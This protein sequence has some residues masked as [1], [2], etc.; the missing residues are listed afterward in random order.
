L[1]AKY[2][3]SVARKA[4]IESEME[5]TKVKLTRAEKLLSGL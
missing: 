4:K 1:R 5:A 2:D 3:A